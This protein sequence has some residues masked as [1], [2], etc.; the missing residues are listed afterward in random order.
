MKK[1][2]NSVP[3]LQ[4]RIDPLGYDYSILFQ[5][6]Y[7]VSERLKHFICGSLSVSDSQQASHHSQQ[8]SMVFFCYRLS[9]PLNRHSDKVLQ[10]SETKWELI[11]VRT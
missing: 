11:T 4:L 5:E 8:A 1:K 10:L 6:D 3:Y 2:K 7:C 9:Q